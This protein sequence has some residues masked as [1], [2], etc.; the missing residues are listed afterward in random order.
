MD[1]AYG[2]AYY[3]ERSSDPSNMFL[4]ALELREKL[5]Q[6]PPG[7]GRPDQKRLTTQLLADIARL[8][9]ELRNYADLLKDFQDPVIDPANPPRPP[10]SLTG[11]FRGMQKYTRLDVPV[12]AIFAIPH[13]LSNLGDPDMLSKDP[14]AAAA[15]EAED[16]KHTGSQA[17]AF[18]HGV[19]SARVV[20]I[21]HASHVIFQTNEQDV[22]REMN[23]FLAKLP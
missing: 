15:A 6:L 5:L 20:R 1:A 19:P 2:Y 14:A 13:A 7:G 17:D 12:R 16:V 21:A 23:A 3:N 11:I 8:E 4:D 22:L 10:A 9:R 18:E